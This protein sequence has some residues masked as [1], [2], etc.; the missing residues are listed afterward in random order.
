MPP[1]AFS[2]DTLR[3]EFPAARKYAYL[4][5]AAVGL[6]PATI[7]TLAEQFARNTMSLG[8]MRH[9]ASADRDVAA[10]AET[11]A[12]ELLGTTGGAALVAASAIDTI[13]R[14][15]ARLKPPDRGNV[16]C[17]ADDYPD[18]VTCWRRYCEV[19]EVEFRLAV[20]SSDETSAVL[21][22]LRAVLDDRTCVLAVSHVHWITGALLPLEALSELR[23]QYGCL[24]VVDASQSLGVASVDI[25]ETPVDLLVAAGF[26]WM[27]GTFG[28]ALAWASEG[29]LAR[30]EADPL[31]LPRGLLAPTTQSYEAAYVL[32][33][34]IDWL[35]ERKLIP[36]A[37]HVAPIVGALREELRRHG[38]VILGPDSSSPAAGI[39]SA[40]VPGRDARQL[41]QAAAG[42][43]VAVSERGG[44]VRFA[45]HFYTQPADVTT[46][47]DALF[48]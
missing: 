20:S 28:S 31:A 14:F 21:S 33:A 8:T 23:Q 2:A 19:N 45:P 41:V 13:T 39:I 32:A 43:G 42:R 5:T 36:A 34:S 37:E 44:A 29:A 7:Q 48:S 17:L 27:C 40:Q 4:D 16:V 35:T 30:I 6:V 25:D 22:S 46:A 1:A 47:M 10:L 11:S 24:L 9:Q 18:L 15:A 26:K 12:R 38:A 3:S